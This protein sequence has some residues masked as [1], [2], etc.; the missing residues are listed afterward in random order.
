MEDS[1]PGKR[2]VLIPKDKFKIRKV[3]NNSI[4]IAVP[5]DAAP[6]PTKQVPIVD[7]KLIATKGLFAYRTK[8]TEEQSVI[9]E[10]KEPSVPVVPATEEPSV[11]VVPAIE[12]PSAPAV[13]IQ[14]KKFKKPTRVI[15]VAEEKPEIPKD[16][17]KDS[18]GKKLPTDPA[19]KP[20]EDAMVLSQKESS[21][22]SLDSRRPYQTANRYF[23][24]RLIPTIYKEFA[25]KERAPFDAEA[26]SKMTL[27][28][29]NYQ[30]FIR[31]YMRIDSPSRGVLVYHGLGSGKTCSSIAAAEALFSETNRK[32]IVMTPVSLQENFINEISFCGFRQYKTQNHWVKF[33]LYITKDVLDQ[34]LLCF[35]KNT[36]G[37]PASYI[38]NIIK[39]KTKEPVIWI[40]D[41]EQKP[42]FD[43][44]YEAE[45]AQIKEQIRE[46][47]KN[48]VEFIGY[49]GITRAKLK[50]I[51]LNDPTYFDNATII[52]DEIHNLTRL[53]KGRLE[54]YLKVKKTDG[55]QRKLPLSYE[56]V[57]T[58]RWSPKLARDDQHYERGY[59]LYRLLSEAR[60]S[61]IIGLSG[62]PIVNYPEEIAVLGN[63]L[64][65]Y[66][67]TC[68]H[69]LP[70]ASFDEVK[71]KRVL[72]EHRRVDYYNIEKGENTK[73]FYTLLEPGFKKGFNKEGKFAGVVYDGIITTIEAVAEEIKKELGVTIKETTF[74]AIPLFPIGAK[75][76]EGSFINKESGRMMNSN[77]FVKRMSG[78]VSY[79]K[80][81]RKDYMPSVNKDVVV[82]IPMSDHMLGS[83][84]EARREERNI[85][86]KKKKQ[87]KKVEGE[88]AK[89]TESV[90]WG[91]ITGAPSDSNKKA[92]ASYRFRSRAMCNYVFPKGI[93][94]PFPN[95]AQEA[96]IA[97]AIT[98]PVYGDKSEDVTYETIEDA[99]NEDIIVEKEVA[100]ALKEDEQGAADEL[101]EKDNLAEDILKAATL[102]DSGI[103]G[104]EITDE[105]RAKLRAL[106]Y[107]K[108]IEYTVNLLRSN[109]DKYFSMDPETET[110]GRL[111]TY[112][113][114][115]AK[116]IENINSSPGSSLVYSQFKTLEG[117]GI[118]GIALEASGYQQIRITLNG[119]TMNFTEDTINS[120]V[121]N[122]NQPRYMVFSGEEPRIVRQ[123]L[124]N[125]FN[126][127]WEI[128]LKKELKDVLNSAPGLKE[129]G[130][131]KGEVCRVFMITGAGAEGLSLKNVRTVHLME[132]YW[133]KVRMDQVKGRAVRIC[134]HKDLPFED[135]N[136]D[137][138]T[139]ISTLTEEQLDEAEEIYIKDD[140][141]TSDEYIYNVSRMKEKLNNDF[142]NAMQV[143]AVDCKLNY[144]DNNMYKCFAVEDA[145]DNEFLYDPRLEKDLLWT[146]Q[147]FGEKNREIQQRIT[148]TISDNILK[149]LSSEIKE[150]LGGRS[151]IYT[152][153]VGKKGRSY[154]G[155]FTSDEYTHPQPFDVDREL[156]ELK[157]GVPSFWA[158]VIA[159][160][161]EGKMK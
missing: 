47:V 21:K 125:T 53:M 39:S 51:A 84:I 57:T 14:T 161:K 159:K 154:F 75:D 98:E 133:N 156:G 2:G 113:P 146:I 3:K 139:Y 64:H 135:R 140:G 123:A 68:T 95:D 55:K 121:N 56:P 137:I 69:S 92:V 101:E 22:Y 76:F 8:K 71:V 103:V 37:I 72:E 20:Y 28:T 107:Q 100:E 58:E 9:P 116:I 25:T 5:K 59:L 38:M 144:I 145:K 45:K 11:P 18:S 33:N 129:T 52:V 49:T 150:F 44:L 40:P 30:K 46:T 65:G 74:E 35:I 132:P 149:S 155:I 106:P 157:D 131:K 24:S 17:C 77:T 138:Y 115:F 105:E 158:D 41:Y 66:F 109:K 26:C 19:Y 124:I 62:T 16:K 160:I 1:Q 81:G 152:E 36:I 148:A 143:G 73:I 141:K 153:M 120:F 136:V 86:E 112:S 31:E 102:E 96:E 82:E 147:R 80:G 88:G 7:G 126:M 61:K 127:N 151:L 83:Y 93:A 91:L 12:E 13:Q 110:T 111:D 32:I 99:V 118:L 108:R 90:N 119:D 54:K 10:I 117:I 85:E 50:D 42:N 60:N 15:E 87:N 29:Y 114:K 78:I 94:R 128:G 97:A 6:V 63:I 130:N 48:R 89:I 142:L 79:Y 4:K 134:S 43:T 70:S 67:H 23:F 122:P 34:T 27:Q 104:D